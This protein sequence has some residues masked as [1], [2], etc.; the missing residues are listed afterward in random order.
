MAGGY[1]TRCGTPLAAEARFCPRCG[2]FH[3]LSP[4]KPTPPTPIPPAQQGLSSTRSELRET[5]GTAGLIG[6][7]ESHRRAHRIAASSLLLIAAVLLT[8]SILVPW[9]SITVSSGGTSATVNFLPGSEYSGT[10][11]YDG[12]TFT[13]ANT[14]TSANLSQVGRLYEAVLGMGIV[15]AIA[16]FL[17][18]AVGFAGA[19]GSRRPGGA[20]T[21]LALL[22]L[23]FALIL[24]FLVVAIQPWAFTS[25]TNSSG[26][27]CGG[28][29]NPCNSFWGNV[30]SGGVTGTWGAGL[31]WYIDLAALV[32]LAIGFWLFLSSEPKRF[33]REEILAELSS[34]P[35][36]ATFDSIAAV[37]RPGTPDST[38]GTPQSVPRTPGL[39]PPSDS[40]TTRFCPYC[41][42]ANKM[43]YSFCHRCGRLLPPPP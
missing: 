9:W 19:F 7:A 15:A 41:G 2:T 40:S 42:L 1:C 38:A 17:S 23:A 25:D 10:G 5:N 12:V 30:S 3:D 24:P 21:D 34:A 28:G 6:S 29:S 4:S 14:Y 43:D 26:S 22:S 27:S 8:I 13:S 37:P 39:A 32:L 18:G 33:T 36:P 31:G 35:F 16:A 11:T 20:A